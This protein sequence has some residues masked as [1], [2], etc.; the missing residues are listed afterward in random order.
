MECEDK[1]MIALIKRKGWK[2]NTLSRHS[3]SRESCKTGT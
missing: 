2:K 3:D 1:T